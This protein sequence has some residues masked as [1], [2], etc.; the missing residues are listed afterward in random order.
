MRRGCSSVRRSAKR[1]RIPMRSARADARRG[2]RVSRPRETSEP[3]RGRG[4]VD[5]EGSAVP[6]GEAEKRRSGEAAKRQR[7]AEAAAAGG[8]GSGRRKRK[9]KRQAEAEAAGG[10]RKRQR[11][12]EAAAAG[13]SGKRKRKRQA[14]AEAEAEAAGGSGTG[15]RRLRRKRLRL[16]TGHM[17]DT[18]NPAIKREVPDSAGNSNDCAPRTA[19]VTLDGTM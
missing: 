15:S 8:S 14:E 4:P 12:A 7:Q 17:G 5:G 10:R 16:R 3:T 9:R 18:R 19:T 2:A 11:Q 6:C 1:A 13:G